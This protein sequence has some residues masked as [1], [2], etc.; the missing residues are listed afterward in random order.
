MSLQPNPAA[1]VLDAVDPP[2]PA[3]VVVRRGLTSS[4]AAARL[5]TDG[6][7]TLPGSGRRKLITIARETLR[8]PMFLLFLLAGLIYLSLGDL[9]EGLTL[10][11]F[12]LVTLAMTLVQE[13]R[14]ERTLE[15][16]RDLSSP[17][18]LVIRDGRPQSPA[19]IQPR[20]VP[21]AWLQELPSLWPR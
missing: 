8:E 12:I 1:L 4:E 20:R 18:A 2:S 6:P 10:F 7:N 14:A 5:A 11:G 9:Q 13:G 21:L 15:A 16:L 19:T 17:R 3:E